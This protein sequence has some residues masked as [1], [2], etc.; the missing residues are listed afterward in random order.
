MTSR[1]RSHASGNNSSNRSA[2]SRDSSG[3]YG[4]ARVMAP[5][6]TGRFASLVAADLDND[7]P[8]TVTTPPAAIH[9]SF[10]RHGLEREIRDQL[11]VI[12]L[13]PTGSRDLGDHR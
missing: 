2:D 7:A 9:Q 10:D 12:A 5:S 11:D 3:V 13:V 8:P 4:L 1:S 6:Q